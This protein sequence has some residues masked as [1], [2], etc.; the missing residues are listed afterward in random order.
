M[1]KFQDLKELVEDFYWG[2]L[3]DLFWIHLCTAWWSCFFSRQCLSSQIRNPQTDSKDRWFGFQYWTHQRCNRKLVRPKSSKKN[4][5]I[6]VNIQRMAR[7][8]QFSHERFLTKAATILYVASRLQANCCTVLH[9]GN[10]LGRPWISWCFSKRFPLQSPKCASRCQK[11]RLYEDDGV[12]RILEICSKENLM[13]HLIFFFSFFFNGCYY[14]GK[15]ITIQCHHLREYIWNILPTT[16]PLGKSKWSIV[17]I[18][19]TS[20]CFR[21]EKISMKKTLWIS[22]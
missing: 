17:G 10:F 16:Y 8:S 18:I 7:K 4:T 11:H 22:F 19:P 13:F 6:D 14:H 21:I 2:I 9:L 5:T 20:N 1:L 12:L 15:S 3:G